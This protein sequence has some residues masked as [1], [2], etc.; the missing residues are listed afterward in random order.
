MEEAIGKFYGVMR[1]F[2]ILFWVVVTQVD[3]VF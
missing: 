2:Y 3:T 1:K